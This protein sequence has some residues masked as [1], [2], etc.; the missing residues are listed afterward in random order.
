MEEIQVKMAKA[1]K[2]DIQ[3]TI[4]FLRFI[5]EFMEYGTHTPENE[6]TEEESIDLTD[7]QFVERLRKLWGGRF[8]PVGVDCAWSRVVFGCDMLIN[9]AC[10][11]DA[12][13]LELR[14]DWAKLIA[15]PEGIDKVLEGLR[16]NKDHFR[17]VL[18]DKSKIIESVC[19]YADRQAR[20]EGGPAWAFISDITA[21]GSGVSSAIY[22][23]Y[24]RKPEPAESEST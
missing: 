23:L 16:G 22:E 4:E 7:E 14:P 3:K 15:E 20:K 10:D 13:T 21:H 9:N 11:P 24:R 5:E 17:Q 2:D 19:D 8:R 18:L 6:E 1:T 12:D